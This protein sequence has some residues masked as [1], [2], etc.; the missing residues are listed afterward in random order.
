MSGLGGRI[1][2][3][4]R[5][6]LGSFGRWWGVR[7]VRVVRIRVRI[8]WYTV[9]RLR[10]RRRWSGCWEGHGIVSR[11]RCWTPSGRVRCWWFM[12]RIRRL[13]D[14]II[15]GRLNG[16][17]ITIQTPSAVLFVRCIISSS[18]NFTHG[19][20]K[21]YQGNLHRCCLSLGSNTLNATIVFISFQ[22]V[23]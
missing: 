9:G 8:V 14:L 3:R 6:R 19:C 22:S 5:C 18:Q 17:I 21:D 12:R 2:G 15:R 10:S 20:E 11:M 13:V 7:V 16:V 1:R 23:Q 4:H